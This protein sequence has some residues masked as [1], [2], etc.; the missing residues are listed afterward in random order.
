[1]FRRR[2]ETQQPVGSMMA[3]MEEMP[4]RVYFTAAIASLVLSAIL[5][6]FGKRTAAIFV[7]Q[8]PPMLIL[9]SLFYRLLHP[10]QEDT[11]ER[12]ARMRRKTRA[13]MH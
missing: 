9:L 12:M 5:Y 2:K 6:L 13:A 11:G 4:V 1:M 3:T 10:S 7:G 8:W